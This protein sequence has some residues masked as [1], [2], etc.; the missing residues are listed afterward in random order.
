MWGEDGENLYDMIM[1][2]IEALDE[3]VKASTQQYEKRL[4]VCDTCEALANGICRFCG[5]FVIARAAKKNQYCPD[6]KHS[7]W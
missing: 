1:A 5:C 2:Y 4:E 3:E 7:K 6:P